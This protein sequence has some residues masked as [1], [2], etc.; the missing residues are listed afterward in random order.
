MH[1]FQLFDDIYH[2]TLPSPHGAPLVFVTELSE[3]QR[4]ILK[5]LRIP[6]NHYQT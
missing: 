2:H 4:R 1:D 5:L 6:M 3:L